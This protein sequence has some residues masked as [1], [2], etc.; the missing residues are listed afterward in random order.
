MTS[1]L[2]DQWLTDQ[3]YYR[4][5]LTAG[6]E[7]AGTENPDQRISEDLRDFVNW[8]CRKSWVTAEQRHA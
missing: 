3:A 5:N 2:L 4:L 8:F 6:P 1:C 7:E